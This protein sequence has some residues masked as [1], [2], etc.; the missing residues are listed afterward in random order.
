MGDLFRDLENVQSY[1]D[2]LL[3]LTKGSWE[4]HLAELNEVLT[5]LIKG[6][7]KP[8]RHPTVKEESRCDIENC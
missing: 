5:R 2:D 6:R 1:I 8:Q 7:L 3:V 4:D